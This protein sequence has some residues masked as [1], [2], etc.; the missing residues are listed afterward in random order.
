MRTASIRATS[1]LT[2]T[3]TLS[4][5]IGVTLVLL[6][7]S[8]CGSTSPAQSDPTPSTSPVT[9]RT[10]TTP[11]AVTTTPTR[12]PSTSSAPPSASSAPPS[13]GVPADL[14][15]H[16]WVLESR[17]TV[18]A[19]QPFPAGRGAGITF[20]ADG[21]VAVQTGC[22][23]GTGQALFAADGSMTVGALTITSRG[24]ADADVTAM[25]KGML[26]VL[27]EPLRYSVHD[28]LLTVY[29]LTVTDTGLV[30]TAAP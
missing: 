6:V 4:A 9:Q 25:E 27:A 20:T 2:L 15:G 28:G 26:A 11:G 23:S 10:P 7:V 17:I 14:L 22:N 13:I 19:L 29:P 1:T 24:C 21:A 8:S 12:P 16:P 18:G 5:M 30:F 3:R